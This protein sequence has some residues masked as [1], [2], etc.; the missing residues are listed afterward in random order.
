M[1]PRL[2]ALPAISLLLAAGTAL[3]QSQDYAALPSFATL[4]RADSR[5][6]AGL[7]VGLA[8]GDASAQ[9]FDLHGQYVTGT[10]LGAYLSLPLAHASAGTGLGNLDLGAVFALRNLLTLRAGIVLPTASDDGSA[11]NITAG[12][13]RLADA[14]QAANELTA[15]RLSASPMFRSGTLFARADLG[16]DIVL[17]HPTGTSG[18]PV[19]RG[20]LGGGWDGGVVVVTAELVN[21]IF[22][23]SGR[24]VGDRFQ[25]SF[26]AS[27]RLRIGNVEPSVAYIYGL[28]KVARDSYSAMLLVGLQYVVR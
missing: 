9:R 7:D 10:G 27:A 19:L 17:K 1:R 24:S 18:R 14:V 5:T 3:A 26:A 28:D 23:D 2:I 11:A 20:N 15:L 6:K 8:L 12:W 4:D 21:N 16:A 25:H 13:V 22:T